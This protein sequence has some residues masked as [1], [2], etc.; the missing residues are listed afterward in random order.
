MSSAWKTAGFYT[1][2]NLRNWKRAANSD[3]RRMKT[4]TR[5]GK[6]GYNLGEKKCSR[7][8]L[9]ESREGFRQRGRG[10]PFHVEGPKTEKA[11]EATVGY[12]LVR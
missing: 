4:A 5:K 10:R 1:K 7:Y 3:L 8:G 11:R 9:N 6:H 2:L 12:S